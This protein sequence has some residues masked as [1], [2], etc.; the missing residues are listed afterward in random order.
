MRNILGGEAQ[1]S[2]LCPHAVLPSS[3]GLMVCEQMILF[4]Q[5]RSLC[6]SY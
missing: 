2:P 4:T 6:S 1:V 3:P 5:L